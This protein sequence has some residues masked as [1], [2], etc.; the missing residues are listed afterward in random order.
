MATKDPLKFAKKFSDLELPEID[1]TIAEKPEIQNI[2]LTA[3]PESYLQKGVGSAYDYTLPKNWKIPLQE[4]NTKIT[5]WQAEEDSLTGKMPE[6]IS[7][8]LPNSELIKIRNAG[9]LWI[10]EHIK[11]V[12]EHQIVKKNQ[13]EKTIENITKN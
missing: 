2:F 10:L 7:S 6:H 3:F 5:V 8:L 13:A 11:T 9:H 12:L 4:I 1:K